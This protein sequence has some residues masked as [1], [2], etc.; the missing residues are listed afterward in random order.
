MIEPSNCEDCPPIIA[1]L[2][3]RRPVTLRSIRSNDL[4]AMQAAFSHLSWNARYARFM[5]VTKELPRATLERAVHPMPGREV[6]LVAISGEGGNETIV[7]GAR[8]GV[9][10]DNASCEFA[11][12]VADEW[13]GVGLASRLM[14]ELIRVA[15]RHGL[16]RMEGYVLAENKPMLDLA[17]RLGFEVTASQEGP[18]VKLVRLDLDANH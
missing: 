18:R 17:R 10:P 13:R 4:D 9:A 16:K 6:A 1:R 2:R 5:A 11:I 8:Y 14:K 3:D 12:T 15:R 7:G